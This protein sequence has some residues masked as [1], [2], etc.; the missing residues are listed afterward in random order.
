MEDFPARHTRRKKVNVDENTNV[1][2]CAS[3][4]T[5]EKFLLAYV[6]P[7]VSREKAKNIK[8]RARR[9]SEKVCKEKVKE[10]NKNKEERRLRSKS[11][12]LCSH[13]GS[14]SKERSNGKRSLTTSESELAP[15][16][17]IKGQET[18]EVKQLCV[19]K[20]NRRARQKVN[21]NGGHDN[22]QGDKR[23][24]AESTKDNESK[25]T[26]VYIRDEKIKLQPTELQDATKIIE[27]IN[28]KEVSG[29][30]LKQDYVTIVDINQKMSQDTAVPE[31]IPQGRELVK[32]IEKGAEGMEVSNQQIWE[33]LQNLQTNFNNKMQAISDDIAAVKTDI[34]MSTKQIEEMQK[35]EDRDNREVG[36]GTTSKERRFG[37]Q[38]KSGKIHW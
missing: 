29:T 32:E 26:K 14:Y 38:S 33:F 30:V 18:N 31:K 16:K 23:K 19:S 12:P 15:H 17:P 36:R 27:N 21:E 5:E 2:E 13:K 20:N 4:G 10:G 28:I 34:S 6:K 7:T 8:T 11:G 22:V 9:L 35:M 1:T 37:G 3:S 24:T 25:T